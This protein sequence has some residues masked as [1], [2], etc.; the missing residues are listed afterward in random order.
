[1][2]RKGLT[3]LI[4]MAAICACFAA[5]G[6]YEKYGG[7]V[8]SGCAAGGS[9]FNGIESVVVIDDACTLTFALPCTMESP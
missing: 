6:A 7:A 1:M 8:N 5:A 3:F 4:F 9:C 2:G